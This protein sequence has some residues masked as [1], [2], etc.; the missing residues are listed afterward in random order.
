MKN[1]PPTI[2]GDYIQACHL[3]G[4][5]FELTPN[6]TLNER[7]GFLAGIAPPAGEVPD[8]NWVCIGNAGHRGIIEGTNS[9]N[10][11][12]QHEPTDGGPF[13]IIPFHL[14]PIAKD[15]TPAERE[16]YGGRVIK[17][18]PGGQK[19]VAYY[20]MKI[21]KANSRPAMVV[22]EKV[23]GVEQTRPFIPEASDL[24]PVPND[25]AA[26]ETV[27]ANGQQVGIRQV[28]QFILSATQIEAVI[29]AC[30]ILYDNAERAVIS[31][32][33]LVSGVSYA[34]NGSSS[35]GAVIEFKDVIAAQVCSHLITHYALPFVNNQVREE[36]V[37]GT[38]N[39]L[40]RRPR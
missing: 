28:I 29:D 10:T 6:T 15:L 5:P 31:E 3:T 36:M 8:T 22:I 2:Y 33:C 25:L 35:G 20:L 12:R 26:E 23:G 32:I 19:Y 1:T 11:G 13:E 7:L 18:M 37:L 17:E 4:A 38:S 30:R 16:N 21:D 39:P 40:M 24:S 34:T 27:T 9:W 14:R